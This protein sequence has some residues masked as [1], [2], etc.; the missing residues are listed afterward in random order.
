LQ[1]HSNSTQVHI[2]VNKTKLPRRRGSSKTPYVFDARGRVHLSPPL[3]RP[4]FEIR[5]HQ[6]PPS[7]TSTLPKPSPPQRVLR[8]TKLTTVLLVEQEL[9]DT[10]A[11]GDTDMDVDANLKTRMM[12]HHGGREADEDEQ[13]VMVENPNKRKAKS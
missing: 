10:D 2:T 7:P 4:I 11:D 13:D 3:P 8:P 6:N 5:G 1:H 9:T 12:D